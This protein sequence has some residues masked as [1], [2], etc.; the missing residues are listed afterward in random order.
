MTERAKIREDFKR[1]QRLPAP[2][3]SK[4]IKK[5]KDKP[6]ILEER[7]FPGND[8]EKELFSWLSLGVFKKLTNWHPIKKYETRRDA[9]EGMSKIIK[10]NRGKNWWIFEYR[11]I[12]KEKQN[13]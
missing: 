7:Q 9:E 2:D 13:E 4:R 10:N 12:E 3:V 11:I 5:K 1:K 6:F 8:R